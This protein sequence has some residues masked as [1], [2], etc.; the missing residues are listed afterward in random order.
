MT[1][2]ADGSDQIF[3]SQ[4]VKPGPIPQAP[5]TGFQGYMSGAPQAPAKGFAPPQG[6]GAVGGMQSSF[7][8]SGAAPSLDVLVAQV[9][10]SQDSLA[11]V[12]NQLKTKGLESQLSRSRSHLLRNKF[13]DASTYFRAANARLGAETPPMPSQA[14][15]RPLERFIN[16]VA[17]GESQLFAAKQKILDM[18]DV[19]DQLRPAD[20]MLI[21]IKLSQAQQELE[22]SS[23]LLGKMIDSI[24]TTLNIAL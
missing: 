23:T 11:N 17:D 14:G 1:I 7:A 18:K 9:G 20:F 24:K 19:G 21:Q 2:P 22:Y 10:T 8:A 3:S 15:A 4:P 13:S 16:Y 12:R 6:P 5:G